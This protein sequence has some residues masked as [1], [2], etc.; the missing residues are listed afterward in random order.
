MGMSQQM[1]PTPSIQALSQGMSGGNQLTGQTAQQYNQLMQLRPELQGTMDTRAI[2]A[3]P[4][5]L[6]P[7][8]Q[9]TQ[10]YNQMMQTPEGQQLLN[11]LP[12]GVDKY[13]VAANPAAYKQWE[14]QAKAQEAARPGSTMFAPQQN[15]PPSPQVGYR[16]S[17]P[18]PM[19][20]TRPQQNM[21]PQAAQGGMGGTGRQPPSPQQLSQGLQQQAMMQR[22]MPMSNQRQPQG[23]LAG[24]TA[25][26]VQNSARAAMGS[27]RGY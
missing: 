22:Q 13:A 8:I 26:Q 20:S 12:A 23:G 16:N 14:Q 25:P 6:Q 21:P 7:M 10:A 1:M 19:Y 17:N 9:A 27:F 4:S 5:A 2:A 15:M 18:N 11:N 3:N 24:R